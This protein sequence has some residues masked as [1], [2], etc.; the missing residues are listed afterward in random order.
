MPAWPRL[1]VSFV[2]RL[3]GVSVLSVFKNSVSFVPRLAGVSVPS[4]FTPPCPAMC[5]VAAPNGIS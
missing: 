5:A 3:A 4:V 1:S 2:P